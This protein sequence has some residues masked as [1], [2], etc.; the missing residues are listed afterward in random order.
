MISG[1]IRFSVLKKLVLDHS[2]SVTRVFSVCSRL[3]SSH[4]QCDLSAGILS[5]EFSP[6]PWK[7]CAAVCLVCAL[8]VFTKSAL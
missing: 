4:A 8:L 2:L 7:L 3:S 1:K 6:T 5:E